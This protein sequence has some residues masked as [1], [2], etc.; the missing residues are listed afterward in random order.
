MKQLIFMTIFTKDEEMERGVYCAPHCQFLRARP[1]GTPLARC[2]AFSRAQATPE[3]EPGEILIVNG[4]YMRH[5]SCRH[6][7]DRMRNESHIVRAAKDLQAF[8]AKDKKLEEEWLAMCEAREG[9][10]A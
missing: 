1:A 3:C 5:Q 6:N 8:L 7:A 2:T 9:G 10:K 4:E